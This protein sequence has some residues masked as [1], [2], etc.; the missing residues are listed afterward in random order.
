MGNIPNL[1]TVVESFLL[2]ME[3]DHNQQG[4]PIF[5]EYQRLTM[6]NSVG[7]FTAIPSFLSGSCPFYWGTNIGDSS[8][9]TT[10]HQMGLSENRVSTIP[11]DY[12]HSTY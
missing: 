1:G 6:E 2:Y 5:V 7:D 11:V 8:S 10:T 12:R 4:N 3:N 9:E